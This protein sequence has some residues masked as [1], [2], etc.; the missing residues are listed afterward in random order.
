MGLVTLRAQDEGEL[1]HIT[2][3][4]FPLHDSCERKFRLSNFSREAEVVWR[5]TREL[6]S[7]YNYGI[8]ISD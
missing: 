6:T 3:L 5:N 7:A 4:A 1:A 8:T 2:D